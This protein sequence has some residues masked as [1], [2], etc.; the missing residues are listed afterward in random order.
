MTIAELRESFLIRKGVLSARDGVWL[1]RV[2][3]AE[4]DAAL[5]RLP[6]S[7]GWI[8]LPWLATPLQVEWQSPS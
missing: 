7:I 8:K 2:E 6:W 1:L 5:G 3:R 4:Q